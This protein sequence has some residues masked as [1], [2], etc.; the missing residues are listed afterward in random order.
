MVCQMAFR[1]VGLRTRGKVLAALVFYFLSMT[2]SDG[3]DSEPLISFF[4]FL[5]FYRIFLELCSFLYG[6]VASSALHRL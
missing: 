3:Q 2:F 6:F 5:G 4:Y 1:G